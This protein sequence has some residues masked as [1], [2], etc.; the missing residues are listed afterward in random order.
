MGILLAVV[1]MP[2]TVFAAVPPVLASPQSLS[3]AEIKITGDEF[4]VLQNNSGQ[5]ITDLSSYWLQDFNNVNPL[6]AG[7]SNSSQ[8][9]PQVSLAAGQT[10]L[11]SSVAMST[12]GASVAGKLNI[13]L[14][15]GGG[16][17]ELVQM[18]QNANGAVAQTPG[19]IVSWSSGA[20][21]SIQNVPSST[22]DPKA[23]WYRYQNG[24]NYAWQQADLN[25]SNACQ[26]DVVL[27]GTTQSQGLVPSLGQAS[28][29]PPASI[30]RLFSE[31]TGVSGT[32][33]MPVAD[34]GLL[35]PQLS[36]LLP[37]PAGTG[38]DGTDEYI[39][40]Y[41]PNAKSFDLSGFVLQVGTTTTHKYIFPSGTTIPSKSFKAF[42]SNETDL[43]M[44][45][46]SG[47]AML[48]DPLGTTIGQTE[49]YGSAKDGQAWAIANGKWY[50]TAQATPDSANVINQ[51]VTSS[52]S[53]SGAKK[54]SKS[55]SAV[56]GAS[57]SNAS[58]FTSGSP[59]DAVE[60]TPIHPW[61][62]ALVAAMAILY[63]TYEYR[64]DLANRIYQFRKNR[65]AR[66]IAGE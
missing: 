55:A 48:L 40:L 30:V 62:L 12:C 31:N 36:E 35:A 49:P 21:G 15:D 66:R 5:N 39:E 23:I 27:S 32:P 18:S 46:T 52:K 25:S 28:T 20:N 63:G 8:Q 24:T 44:S 50:W 47:Q 6:A 53:S 11:L 13:S 56:K 14:T 51:P 61:T 37:N 57:T 7:V 34:L 2:M 29:S 42:Y 17:L 26:L 10:L 60:V 1:P 38:T 9:L 22:K 59:T 19:D 58:N 33:T 4:L 41:N 65:A 16:F 45:N 54:S 43:S 64:V 3:F